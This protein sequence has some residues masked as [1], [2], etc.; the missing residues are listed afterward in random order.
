MAERETA[1][2]QSLT[3]LTGELHDLRRS[4]DIADVLGQIL[5]EHH[6]AAGDLEEFIDT[7]AAWCDQLN[8]PNGRELS[9]HLRTIAHHVA[10]LRDQLAGA[11]TELA[12]MPDV[13]PGNA[14]PLAEA[15]VPA[16]HEFLPVTHTARGK[17]VV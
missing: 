16:R 17:S 8:T 12:V 1:P 7:A 9:L 5:D 15:P 4:A 6:G 14:P 13:T 3:T 2:G 11:Q 10:F